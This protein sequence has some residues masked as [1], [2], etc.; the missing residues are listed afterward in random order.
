MQASSKPRI[1]GRAL[2]AL[3]NRK[4]DFAPIKKRLL[5][6]G[7][8]TK[9]VEGLQLAF[10]Q[11]F[12]MFPKLQPGQTYVMLFDDVD[13]FFHVLIIHTETYEKLC[14]D[15]LGFKVH[16]HPLGESSPEG[17]GA[18]IPASVDLLEAEF[19]EELSPLLKEWRKSHERGAAKVSC[20]YRGCPNGHVSQNVEGT[21]PNGVVVVH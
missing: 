14:F 12:S 21:L 18:G 10:C 5:A 17:I 9:D 6:E 8:V 3:L 4:F 7:R 20:A 2:A 16:H 19:G 11:W 1:G 15:H 13:E